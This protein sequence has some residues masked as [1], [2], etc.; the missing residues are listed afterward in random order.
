[1]PVHR[2]RTFSRFSPHDRKK[3]KDYSFCSS[4]KKKK[5]RLWKRPLPDNRRQKRDDTFLFIPPFW[6]DSHKELFPG[7][8]SQLCGKQDYPFAADMGKAVM[9]FQGAYGVAGRAPAK[10]AHPSRVEH[11][12]NLPSGCCPR[13]QSVSIPLGERAKR[14]ARKCLSSISGAF[15]FG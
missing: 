15:C 1:M 9:I 13:E 11:G 4:C 7:G 10:N 14:K 8:A 2:G 6:P 5:K 12:Q 3:E